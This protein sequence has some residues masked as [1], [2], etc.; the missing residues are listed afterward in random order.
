MNKKKLTV[1]TLPD[2]ARSLL[3]GAIMSMV[4]AGLITGV[5]AEQLIVLL[6]LRDA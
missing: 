1:P 2:T 4:N 3:K 5:D 6:Q